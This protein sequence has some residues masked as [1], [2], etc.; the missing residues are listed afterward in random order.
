M[1]LCIV[2]NSDIPPKW[3]ANVLK[4]WEPSYIKVLRPDTEVVL[5]PAKGGLRG[6]SSLDYDNPYFSFLGERPIIES[7]LEAEKEGF[8]AAWVNCFT[9]PGVRVARALVRMPIIGPAETTLHYAC[10]LGRKIAV[11]VPNQPGNVAQTEEQLRFHGLESRLAKNGI[12][13]EKEPFAKAYEKGLKDPQYTVDVVTEVARQCV[14]DGAEVI[15]IGCC[16]TGPILSKAGFNKLTF[17]GQEVPILDPMMVAAKMAEASADIRR[18]T[19]L[20]IPSHVRNHAIPSEADWKRV[21][22][23]FGLTS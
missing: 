18:G 14:A 3:V 17:D 10:Q 22:A 13:T 7:F 23:V 11:I 5:K 15:V 12:R 21:R 9:D 19:G 4:R 20:P 6:D 16:G 1:R 8:D 2:S